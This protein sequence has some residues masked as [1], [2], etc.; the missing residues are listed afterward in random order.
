MDLR[1]GR[2]RATANSGPE[3]RLE[4]LQ[5]VQKLTQEHLKRRTVR[6]TEALGQFP[7]LNFGCWRAG[8]DPHPPLRAVGCPSLP[9]THA[10]D[11]LDGFV[12]G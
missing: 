1:W 3:T 2:E 8:A 4:P 9:L 12:V 6:H 7:E 11:S 10:Y 5:V